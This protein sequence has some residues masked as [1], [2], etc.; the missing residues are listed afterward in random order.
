MIVVKLMGGLGNQM[1]QYA[2]AQ[3]LKHVYGEE[4]CF[5]IDSYQDDKQRSLSIHNLCVG[6]IL[7]WRDYISENNRKSILK[8]GFFQSV[9]EYGEF[10]GRFRVHIFRWIRS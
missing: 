10:T 2:F 8:Q 7:N 9:Q 6:D 3:E 4:V 5:D 1:F